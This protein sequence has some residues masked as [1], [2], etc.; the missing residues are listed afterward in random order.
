M[1]R[2]EVRD[3][4][5]SGER[6]ESPDDRAQVI[7]SEY[8]GLESPVVL[9]ASREEV[10]GIIKVGIDAVRLEIRM[11]GDLGEEHLVTMDRKAFHKLLGKDDEGVAEVLENAEPLDQRRRVGRSAVR[12]GGDSITYTTMEHAGEPHRGKTTD[13]EKALVKEHLDKINARL[14]ASGKR[15]IDLS[16]PEH[17]TRYGLEELAKQLEAERGAD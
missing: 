7:V 14:T 17:V 1:A 11:P 16:N 3:S 15:T 2:R 12:N 9:D 13:E 5:F 6:I 4:D 10:P 8:P